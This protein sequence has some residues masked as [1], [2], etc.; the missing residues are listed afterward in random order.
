MCI[1]Y[2]H[3]DTI[4]YKH[5]S[6]FVFWRVFYD[7]PVRFLSTAPGGFGV[8]IMFYNAPAQTSCEAPVLYY[9]MMHRAGVYEVHGVRCANDFVRTS[10]LFF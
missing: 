9:I 5:T 3:I 2:R 4:C 6:H 8:G 1:I 10:A 7:A